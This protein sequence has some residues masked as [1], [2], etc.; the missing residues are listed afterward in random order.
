MP[1][2]QANYLEKIKN[3]IEIIKISNNINLQAQ[4]NITS[5][6]RL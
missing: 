3:F 2:I 5:H 4:K 6:K 1:T